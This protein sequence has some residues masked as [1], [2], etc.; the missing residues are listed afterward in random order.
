MPEATWRG[1]GWDVFSA[2]HLSLDPG[3][4]FPRAP[5][6]AQ[7]V[8]SAWRSLSL[9]ASSLSLRIKM[10]AVS[11]GTFWTPAW[12]SGPSHMVPMTRKAP[13]HG[14]PFHRP[15]A[16]RVQAWDALLWGPSTEL[17]RHEPRFGAPGCWITHRVTLGRGAGAAFTSLQ[18]GANGCTY[19]RLC[20]H[21]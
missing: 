3:C 15:S 5:G 13:V 1:G 17:A 14:L 6:T 16:P 11:Q 20:G 18:D 8:P 9:P 4:V 21:G 10:R 2:V 12:L 19:G 7:A